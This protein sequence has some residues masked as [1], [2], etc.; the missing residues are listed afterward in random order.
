[1]NFN[2]TTIRAT[3]LTICAFAFIAL[4]GLSPANAQLRLGNMRNDTSTVFAIAPREATRPLKI[5]EK[6]IEAGDFQQA[7][8]LLGDLLADS[9]LNEYLIPDQDRKGHP[10]HAISLR[11][12]AEQLLGQIPLQQR[13][14]YEDKY[15]VKA[16]V[17]L[18]KAIEANDTQAIAMTSRLYFHTH[19]GLEATMLVGHAHLALGRPVMAAFAFEKVAN[20]PQGSN[21]FDPEATLLAAVCWS[22]N[23]SNDRSAKLLEALK[24]RRGDAKVRFYGKT[25]ALFDESTPLPDRWSLEAKNPLPEPTASQKE[26]ETDLP[27][28]QDKP[29]QNWLKQIVDS[30]PLESHP[31]INQW[32]VFRG[33]SQRNAESGSGFPLLSPRWSIRTVTDPVDEKGI[34]E[35][36]QKLIR[37]KNSPMPKVH[38]L[39][40]G[41]TLVIRTDDRMF[42]VDADNGKRIWSYPPANMFRSG[43][44]KSADSL[45]RPSVKLHQDKLRER[46][47]LDTLYGQI[48][49]DGNSIFLIPNPGISTDRGDWR[50]RPPQ[51]YDEPTDL[52]QFNELKSLDL[53]QQGALQWEV[54]GE[55]GLDEPKLAKT[56]FLGAPLP[57]GNR[58]YAICVQEQNVRLVVLDS[59]TGRLQWAR[60][61]ASTEES[62]SF[63]EE[64][65]RRL[66]GATPSEANGVLICPTGLNAIV[67]VDLAT[68]SLSWGFQFK[69]PKRAR[70][71]RLT[72][73]LKKWNTMWR[74]AT[75]TLTGGVVVY[76]PVDSDDVYCLNLQTGESLWED[77]RKKK[78]RG[79]DMP[80]H[81]ETV[82]DGNIIIT[83]SDRLKA[84]ELSTGVVAWQTKL[85][86]Y[87]LVSG[88]G[89]VSGNHCFIP[90][91][92][93]KVLRIDTATG[94]INGVAISEK[95]L[96]NL[97]SFRGDVISHGADHLT[98]YPRDEP[99]RLMLAKEAETPL[100]DHAQLSIKAQLHLLDEQ[101][102][103][104]VDAISRAY[105]LFPNSNYAGILVQALTRLNDVDFAKAEQ[106]SD[107]YQNLFE[108]QDLH[109]LLRGRVAGLMKLN[110]YEEAFETLLRI[111]DTIDL[112]S[113]S[114]KTRSTRSAGQRIDDEDS[115]VFLAAS[116]DQ[117]ESLAKN[118]ANAELTMKLIQ[119]LRWKLNDVYQA[120]DAQAR[121]SYH[122]AVAEHLISF[123]S[124][125]ITLRHDRIRIFPIEAVEINVRMKTA[126]EL[127]AAGHYVRASSLMEDLHSVPGEGNNDDVAPRHGFLSRAKSLLR[128]MANDDFPGETISTLEDAIVKLQAVQSSER[129]ILAPDLYTLPSK[130]PRV[131]K[132]LRTDEIDF[133]WSHDVTRLEQEKLSSYFIGTQPFCEVV[134]TDQ[135][136]LHTLTFRY[137]DE[138]REFQMYDRLGRFVHKIYLDPDG[139]FQGIRLGTK[140][141]I[142]LHNSLL[143]LCIDKEM[144]AI[145]WEKFIRGKPALLW[146]AENVVC[147]S[148][149]LTGGNKHGISVLTDEKLKRLCRFTGEVLWQRSQV[150]SKAT[151]LG[152]DQSL[153]IWNRQPRTHD[154]IDPMMGRLLS[155]GKMERKFKFAPPPLASKD[156]QLF[157]TPKKAEPASPDEEDDLTGTI[158]ESQRSKYEADVLN[159]FDFN[160]NKVLWTKEVPF[161]AKPT[162]VDQNNLLVLSGD[163]V[164]SMIDMRS[165]ELKFET[166]I[167]ELNKSTASSIVVDKL[168]GLYV[169]TVYSLTQ[170]PDFVTQDDLRVTFKQM[171]KGNAMING[172]IVALNAVTGESVWKYP[173]A[174][175]R[176][177]QLEGLPWESPFLFLARKNIYETRDTSARI[178]IA[179]IDLQSGKLKANE[180][181]TVPVRDNVFYRVT[182]LP[183]SNDDP[184]QS[185]ELQVASLKTKFYLDD[186]ATAPQPVAAL[187]NHGSF[188]RMKKAVSTAQVAPLPAT[189]FQS[190]T[191]QA[192]AAEKQRRVLGK[193]EV[194]LTELEMKKK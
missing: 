164:F 60:H 59:E 174:A 108:K 132:I 58:L 155:S 91:T 106:V 125:S 134:S 182:C 138:F 178:Q 127:L 24:A 67:A 190:L 37:S 14:S 31:I 88:R 102:Q 131:G 20:Q 30:T 157:L 43:E 109:R 116:V 34:Q 112:N 39:A 9:M 8:A 184:Q 159:L 130:V 2:W 33:D 21:R 94:K 82:R 87:G 7:T 80:L 50:N 93:K 152:G 66:A 19:A 115:V 100:D 126:A 72:D 73:Q 147:S 23:G 146:Y 121:Q 140:G 77:R 110:R 118:S 62:V 119:W 192:I 163:G 166:S 177:Q 167:P 143:L 124:E 123:Q 84:I 45:A 133:D 92:S 99:S 103:Q 78:S 165:G 56:F 28:N 71:D 86:D 44:Q 180:L 179:M 107:R 168:K 22:L 161:P 104:S 111:A 5:A 101:Y 18:K 83:S 49:S 162:L 36:Q 4:G 27:S 191:D 35:Y 137:S 79:E 187:T 160:Q 144:F 194:R 65:L 32:L 16:K 68:Q 96:G 85:N 153:T 41:K 189:D 97:I 188:K 13:E 70:V 169:V 171:H 76:T 142:F 1:M 46:L 122:D 95:V 90:T 120:C 173:I 10:T 186:V 136:E 69:E 129:E 185:I 117:A 25:V 139:K 26:G 54:G 193:E 172:N 63:R 154:K 158:F 105:D 47:W 181:L 52:R 11:Q 151:L 42:G 51:V 149:G 57:I 89:Y 81:V 55:T 61:L 17:M 98:A 6:A 176:F 156:L 74:D 175:Q 38:P 75:V 15:G 170:Q 3:F 114:E 150:S 148:S 113:P 64:R 141:R 40:I 12:K 145:D 29:L 135:P 48:S 53:K 128:T 183:H